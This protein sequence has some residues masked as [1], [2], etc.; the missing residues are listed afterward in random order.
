M[1]APK[2]R[3]SRSLKAKAP[4]AVTA[5]VPGPLQRRSSKFL[6]ARRPRLAQEATMGKVTIFF[7]LP[8][9]VFQ[10][11]DCYFTN[12][13]T[14]RSCL[15]FLL[16]ADTLSL[17]TMLVHSYRRSL[18]EGYGLASIHC[19]LKRQSLRL[20]QK[21][22]HFSPGAPITSFLSQQIST[23]IRRLRFQQDETIS[24]LDRR[25]NCESHQTYSSYQLVA[26][27]SGNIHNAVSRHLDKN[28]AKHR[29]TVFSMKK[30]QKSKQRSTNWRRRHLGD[31][32]QQPRRWPG[33]DK[34]VETKLRWD[35]YIRPWP[36]GWSFWRRIY[37]SR[38]SERVK[39]S[40]CESRIVGRSPC[41]S[42]LSLADG[43][44]SSFYN[45]NWIKIFPGFFFFFFF[46]LDSHCHPKDQWPP[47]LTPV[48][49][50]RAHCILI[51]TANINRREETVRRSADTHLTTL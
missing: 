2:L 39:S 29:R 48:T 15:G 23:V 17:A 37:T 47:S 34:C 51:S 19:E 26:S 10:V 9:R 50:V 18:D 32:Q 20:Q 14:Q 8:S 31:M 1:T 13:L 28:R 43:H 3:F 22:G 36:P 12:V 24:L 46:V 41:Y 27:I 6:Q 38:G 49:G 44:S 40:E 7:F 42:F 30:A 5:C 16:T 11:Y 35:V 4:G 33:F 25:R 21:C 45:I